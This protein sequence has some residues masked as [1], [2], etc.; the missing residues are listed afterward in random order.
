MQLLT[1]SRM[2]CYKECHKKH[3]FA[4]ERMI[5]RE[6]DAKALRMGS[7]WHECLEMLANGRAIQATDQRLSEQY[8]QIPEKGDPLEWFYE[9]ETLRRL[10]Y[11]YD[12]YWKESGI[13]YL[14]AEQG[15]NLPLRNPATGKPTPIFMMAGK[16]DGIANVNDRMAVVEHKLLGES[17][18]SDS[19]LWDRYV[20]D[21]Q[22]SL[23]VIAARLLGYDVMSVLGDF[24]RKPTIKPEKVP[25]LDS[26]GK[27]IVLDHANN[28]VYN[29]PKSKAEKEAGRGAPR[30]TGD[31]KK[32]Y[33]LQ[34]RPMTIQEW[35]DKLTKD[36]EQRPEFYFC[37]REIPRLEDQ[38]IEFQEEMWDLQQEIRAAQQKG[39]W[40]RVANRNTCGFCSY[41]H[42][43]T[44]G[45]NADR[46]AL[47][48]GFVVLETPHPELKEPA[49]VVT[50]STPDSADGDQPIAAEAATDA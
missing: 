47:P 37:R 12:W 43:C 25:E 27:K 10:L 20:I 40:Y 1:H 49:D 42:M 14:E 44:S 4:Y 11:G 50:S 48:D 18:E 6:E 32:G 39:R 35:G 19:D 34:S 16:I 2:A 29:D 15:F 23:Y 24:T 8:R 7:L 17:L 36:I 13:E 28:R 22:V 5:R 21:H 45:W 30:Q 3:E 46:D 26:D 41:F 33:V 31:T 9:Y 38:L